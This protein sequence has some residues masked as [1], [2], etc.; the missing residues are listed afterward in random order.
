MEDKHAAFHCLNRN[1]LMRAGCSLGLFLVLTLI[2]SA[3]AQMPL[4]DIREPLQAKA[5]MLII[6]IYESRMLGTCNELYPAVPAYGNADRLLSPIITRAAAAF[7]REEQQVIWAA[8]ENTYKAALPL[9]TTR[10]D[11]FSECSAL[12]QHVGLQVA[13]KFFESEDPK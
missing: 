6:G 4:T 12:A 8:A 2:R 11:A 1:K 3:N 5:R 13:L 10:T 7:S 9:L